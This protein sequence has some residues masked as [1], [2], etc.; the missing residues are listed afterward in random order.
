MSDAVPVHEQFQTAAQQHSADRLGIWLFMTSEGMLFGA[1]F[2]SLAVYHFLYPEAMRA[3]TARLDMVVGGINTAIL[4]TSS[5]TM[6]LAVRAAGEGRRGETLAA[7]AATA[8]LGLVFEAIKV[9][10][11]LDEASQGLF[12]RD[13]GGPA[14]P[15]PQPEARLF[16]HLYFVSTGLHALHLAVGILLVAGLAAIILAGRLRIPQQAV[17]V[18]VIG[19][20]WQFVDVIWVFLYPTLYLVS[21]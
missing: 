11:W 2:L 13:G 1:V 3:A 6:A 5:T 15:L 12:S 19:L 4:L 7:L 14:F 18:E 9:H 16:F 8:V 10:S 21:R 20:Y 17:T